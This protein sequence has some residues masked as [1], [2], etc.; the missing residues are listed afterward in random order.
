MAMVSSRTLRVESAGDGKRLETGYGSLIRGIVHWS[1]EVGVHLM[2]WGA[3]RVCL[4][5]ILF[6]LFA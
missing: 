6:L 2:A 3:D 4:L 1:W 5:L